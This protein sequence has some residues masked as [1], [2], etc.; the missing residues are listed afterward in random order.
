MSALATGWKK[1]LVML[2]FMCQ[3]DWVMGCSGIL[4]VPLRVFLCEISI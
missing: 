3:L 4:G 1:A 2:H